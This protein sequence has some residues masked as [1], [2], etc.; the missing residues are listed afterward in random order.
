MHDIEKSTPDLVTIETEK[1]RGTTTM[2]CWMDW[3]APNSNKYVVYPRPHQ[4]QIYK[5]SS[6]WCILQKYADL[7]CKKEWGT[8]RTK[9]R[10][11]KANGST[12]HLRCLVSAA[13]LWTRSSIVHFQQPKFTRRKTTPR[14][15]RC[16]FGHMGP[17]QTASDQATWLVSLTSMSH[18]LIPPQLQ[19]FRT[20]RYSLPQF[21]GKGHRHLWNH[22]YPL[23]PR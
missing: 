1:E 17:V 18:L 3:I 11:R 5:W 19:S 20:K 10:R 7:K 13:A 16:F 8:L 12:Q 23:P 15:K 9:T 14:Q 21:Q 2:Q 6:N 4:N 22:R